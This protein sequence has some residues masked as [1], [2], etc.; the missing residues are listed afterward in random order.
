MLVEKRILSEK[1]DGL[2]AWVSGI[3][4]MTIQ[5][6]MKLPVNNDR[7]GQ[8]FQREPNVFFLFLGESWNELRYDMQ[9]SIRITLVIAPIRYMFTLRPMG[10]H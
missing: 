6:G 7:N 2:Y 5:C 3:F 1:C 4:D 9:Y 8:H 10:L